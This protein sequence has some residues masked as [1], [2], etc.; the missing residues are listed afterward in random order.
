MQGLE[1]PATNHRNQLNPKL[2]S[3]KKHHAIEKQTIYSGDYCNLDYGF[4]EYFL[5]TNLIRAEFHR[6]TPRAQRTVF[7]L[8]AFNTCFSLRALWNFV[9]IPL[10]RAQ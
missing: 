5:D 4:E 3:G 8:L 2:S 6:K 7:C 10:G 9:F 1:K